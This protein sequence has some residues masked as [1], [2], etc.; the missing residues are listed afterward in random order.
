MNATLAAESARVSAAHW[1]VYTL[2][3]FGWALPF[4]QLAQQLFR[5]HFLLG[6]LPANL[7]F[8]VVLFRTGRVHDNLKLVVVSGRAVFCI[9]M[10][11]IV[12]K[13]SP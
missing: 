10:L 11:E 6:Q 7:Y 3:P 1:D 8:A 5:W 2:G 13:R 12:K 4:R 9:K